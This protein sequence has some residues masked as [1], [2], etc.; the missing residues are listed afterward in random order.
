MMNA[1]ELQALRRIFDMT[2]EE[3]T[4]YI[5]Q[6]NNSETWQRWEAGDTPISPEIIA[7]LKEMKARRQRRIN[8]IVDKINNR[9]G[10]NTMRY[11]PDLSSFQSIYTEGDFIE[12]KIYQSVAAELFVHDLERLC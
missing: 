9:I 4:I 12:W 2:I 6:D 8:A 1:L 10:N 3:C 5:T 7:R 11:F